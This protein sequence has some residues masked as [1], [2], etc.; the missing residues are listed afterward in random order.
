[1]GVA[2]PIGAPFSDQHGPVVRPG[3][4]LD[5]SAAL[6]MLRLNAYVHTA[7]PAGI[8][9]P[10]GPVFSTDSA[11]VAEVGDDGAAYMKA[12]RDSHPTRFKGFGKRQR[13]A[14]RERGA[15]EIVMDD[16]DPAAFDLIFTYKRRQYRETGR[17]DVLAPAWTRGLFERLQSRDTHD[18]GLR[19]CT[20]R[21]GAAL[22]AG[23]VCLLGAETLHSWIVAY[24][25][26]LSDYAPGLQLLQ[27]VV[28][29]APSMGAQRVD[30]ATG[31][32]HYKTLFADEKGEFL[33]GATCAAGLAG[34]LRR[35]A[36][37]AWR[38]VE[39]APIA[40]LAS[41]AGR[42]RRRSAQIASVETDLAG[43][44]RGMI[45]AFAH[46]PQHAA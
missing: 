24:D 21:L 12:K 35:A 46:R 9:R 3:Q 23:E 33:D 15:A 6:R 25:P 13:K 42:L 39:S 43:R 5:L 29:N 18:F 8:A 30:L 2:R 38:V 1:M 7:M 16:P 45:A 31:H 19:V 20:L 4:V 17:H 34:N 36:S 26:V 32:G 28:E 44:A 22:A 11:W 40:P 37:S 10:G 41:A 14:A 27:G